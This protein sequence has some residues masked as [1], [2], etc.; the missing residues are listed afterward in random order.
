MPYTV[1]RFALTGPVLPGLTDALVIGDMMRKALMARTRSVEESQAA[2]ALFSGRAAGGDRLRD[3]HLHAFFLPAD[4]DNDG[5]L[6]HVTVYVPAGIDVTTRK[7]FSKLHRIYETGA[8]DIFTVLAGI[9]NSADYGGLAV[10]RGLTPQL[11]ESR[12]WVSR[13]PF[14]LLRHP[15]RF[16]TGQPKIGVNG[17]QVDGAEDQLRKELVQRG[18]PEPIRIEPSSHA[19]VRGRNLYWPDFRRHRNGGGGQPALPEGFGFVLTFDRPVQ[20]PMCLGYG[21]HFGLGQ[22]VADG[23]LT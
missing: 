5:I 14:L 16:R 20:G 21:C 3:D 10:S 12:V 11:A 15:K 23:V 6:D 2:L 4:D 19:R 8:P 9:G 1:A 17:R 13:T 7:V 22:F 18:F